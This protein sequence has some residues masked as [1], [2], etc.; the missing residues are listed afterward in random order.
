MFL[1]NTWHFLKNPPLYLCHAPCFLSDVFRFLHVIGDQKVVEDRTGFHL[2]GS[3]ERYTALHL[4][5][6]N[7]AL[8]QFSPHLP[9]IKAKN[10]DFVELVDGGI[11]TVFRIFNFRM[12]P[13]SL[14]VGVVDLFGFPLSLRYRKTASNKSS[15]KKSAKY[16]ITEIHQSGFSW[17]MWTFGFL[18]SDLWVNIPRIF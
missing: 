11:R 8:R 6:N 2:R 10:T 17:P 7:I 12:H 1:F 3:P 15:S 18:R 4:F 9:K 5:C 16:P 14:V 13:G